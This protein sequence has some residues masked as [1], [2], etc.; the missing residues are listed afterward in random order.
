M[1]SPIAKVRHEN[2]SKVTALMD[3]SVK[4]SSIIKKVMEDTGLAMWPNLKLEL[5]S[6]IS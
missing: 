3:T 5:V 6:H 2:S 4:I 1:G